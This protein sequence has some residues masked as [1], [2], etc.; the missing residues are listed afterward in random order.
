MTYPFDYRVLT[1]DDKAALLEWA[2][3]YSRR[4]LTASALADLHQVVGAIIQ[5]RQR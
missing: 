5:E 2:E 1:E 3:P 4:P